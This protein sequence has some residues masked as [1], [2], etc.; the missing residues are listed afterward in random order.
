MFTPLSFW[1]LASPTTSSTQILPS[2]SAIYLRFDFTNGLIMAL[3]A[4][5]KSYVQTVVTRYANEPTILVRLF[6]FYILF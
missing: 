4:A 2:L 1:A 6:Y 5:F 3:Q